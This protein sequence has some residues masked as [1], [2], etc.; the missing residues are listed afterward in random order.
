[1]MPSQVMGELTKHLFQGKYPPYEV[2]SLWAIGE[3]NG[4]YTI[5]LCVAYYGWRK[6]K[7]YFNQSPRRVVWAYGAFQDRRNRLEQYER[8]RRNKLIQHR[9]DDI[10]NLTPQQELKLPKRLIR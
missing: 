5:W 3:S 4:T 6:N 2:E 1:M 9:I 7:V 10:F 8:S